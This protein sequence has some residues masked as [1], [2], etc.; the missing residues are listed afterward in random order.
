MRTAESASAQ[1]RGA[2]AELSSL[3]AE[4]RTLK[5]ETIPSLEKDLSRERNRANKST[6][7]ARSLGKSLQ[8]EKKVGEGLMERVEHVNKELE[9]TKKRMC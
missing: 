1:A 5:E 9:A 8:E 2:L 6:E 3:R 7:L 4:Y